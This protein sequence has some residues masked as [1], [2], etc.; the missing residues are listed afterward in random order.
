MGANYDE[1]QD[2]TCP[3]PWPFRSSYRDRLLM[4]WSSTFSNDFYG[5]H[6]GCL[7]GTKGTI[8]HTQSNKVYYLPQGQAS[9]EGIIGHSRSR[10][11]STWITPTS[12]CRTGSIAFAAAR[13]PTA[14]LRSV[15]ARHS[16]AKWLWPLIAAIP[17]CAG[18]RKRRKL[19]KRVLTISRQGLDNES[20]RFFEKRRDARGRG[21]RDGPCREPFLCQRFATQTL[22]GLSDQ[23]RSFTR[24]RNR[25]ENHEELQGKVCRD[26]LRL[27]KVQHGSNPRANPSPA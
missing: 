8:M 26:S 19:C 11:R 15:T 17:P 16:P 24:F 3:T 14:R 25:A 7:F 21:P 4:T 2:G 20:T 13:N 10:I 12:T 23:R 27:G 6:Q 1:P 18:M 9:G 22:Q 5:E